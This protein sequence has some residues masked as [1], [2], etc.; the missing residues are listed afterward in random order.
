MHLHPRVRAC[1][2]ALVACVGEEVNLFFG[3]REC[4]FTSERMYAYIFM[5]IHVYLSLS[6]S[7]S[8]SIYIYR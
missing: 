2:D 5:Y 3:Q 4:V 6:L 7:L 1:V 8:L